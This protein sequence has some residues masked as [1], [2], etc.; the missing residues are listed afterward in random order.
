MDIVSLAD[1]GGDV[2][3]HWQPDG[4]PGRFSRKDEADECLSA[5][6]MGLRIYSIR[7]LDQDSN[8]E[9]SG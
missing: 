9:P 1:T 7:L 4:K 2:P 8:L 6:L 5:L 3:M